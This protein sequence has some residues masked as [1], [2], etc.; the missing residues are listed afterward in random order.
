MSNPKID[1]DSLSENQ[2][3]TL[4]SELISEFENQMKTENPYE[5]GTVKVFLEFKP[6]EQE[7][8]RRSEEVKLGCS[9]F[10]K[11]IF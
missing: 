3:K 6:A 8:K 7:R 1:F 5:N 4:Q 11:I 9:Q 10:S 2:K